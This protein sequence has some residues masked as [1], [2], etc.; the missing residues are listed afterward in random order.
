MRKV[1]GGI[2]NL[3]KWDFPGTVGKNRSFVYFLVV[4]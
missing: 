1:E 4:S 2:Q 3:R